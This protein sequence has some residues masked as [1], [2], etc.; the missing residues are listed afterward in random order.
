MSKKKPA[1]KQ[2]QRLSLARIV[3]YAHDQGYRQPYIATRESAEMIWEALNRSVFRG[4]LV[5]PEKFIVRDYDEAKWPYWGECE[6]LQRGHRYGPYYTKAIRLQQRWPNF[7]KFISVM[8]HE[9][10]HQWEWEKLGTMTHGKS[11]FAWEDRLRDYGICLS[12]TS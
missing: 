1:V 11:F 2:A 10:V 3:D 9:M 7:K 12:V 6:G 4:Q 5:R 8:A